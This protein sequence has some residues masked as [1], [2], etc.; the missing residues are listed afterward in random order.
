MAIKDTIETNLCKLGVELE[1]VENH[2]MNHLTKIQEAIDIMTEQ[3]EDAIREYKDNKLS[4][5]QV[6][7]VSK[8]SRQTFYNNHLLTDYTKAA[9]QLALKDDVFEQIDS[10][11]KQI[12]EHKRIIDD[13]VHRDAQ[14]V[15]YKHE[16]MELRKEMD[17]LR[18][19]IK[20]QDS[21]IRRLR[22]IQNK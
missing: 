11:K 1:N 13:M 7:I 4:I 17:S 14:I 20:S 16:N 15:M 19:T 3:R 18:E 5:N 21:L 9:I 22:H 2:I 12:Q 8:V 6:S 10:C